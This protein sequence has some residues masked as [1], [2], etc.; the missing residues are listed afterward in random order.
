MLNQSNLVKKRARTANG[1]PQS[2][3]K[4]TATPSRKPFAPPD[5]HLD[6]NSLEPSST[7]A[8]QES[9][10]LECGFLRPHTPGLTAIA[11]TP[12]GDRM[13]VARTDYSI[14]YSRKFTQ[15]T[16]TDEILP[17]F[18]DPD[19]SVSCLQFTPC[20]NF[21]V[22]GR[23]N[24]TVTF[25]KIFKCGLALHA[26]LRPGGGAVWN[27]QFAPGCSTS[28]FRLAVACDDGAVRII[29]PDPEF[30]PETL[31]TDEA[32]Y[33]IKQTSKAQARA[34]SLTWVLSKHVASKHREASRSPASVEKLGAIVSGDSEGGLRL[35]CA[36]TGRVLRHGKIPASE[37]RPVLIWTVQSV[38]N[39]RKI[40]CGDDRGKLTIWDV[41]S[42]TMVSEMSPGGVKGAIW[43]STV[44][45][46]S[47]D[48]SEKTKWKTKGSSNRPRAGDNKTK[49]VVVFGC[50]NGRICG[51]EFLD[52]K[53]TK[54]STY[55]G[56]ALHTHDVRGIVGTSDGHFVSAS[57]DSKIVYA[58]LEWLGSTGGRVKFIHRLNN[59]VGRSCI[60]V[61]KDHNIVVCRGSRE[62]EIWH[63]PEAKDGFPKLLLRMKF[64]AGSDLRTCSLSQDCQFLALSDAD[65]FRLYRIWDGAGESPG[66][67]ASFGKVDIV[68]I[69]PSIEASLSGCVSV[70]FCRGSV[71]A[72]SRNRM[73]II[74]YDPRSERYSYSD[75]KD[76]HSKGLF[77]KFVAYG[78][79]TIAT[80]DS[81]NQVFV[82]KLSSEDV[83]WQAD[84]RI[85]N[86]VKNPVAFS[87]S[88]SGEK[89]AFATT[90]GSFFV[91]RTKFSTEDTQGNA[92]ITGRSGKIITC[93]TFGK[94]E[95]N[96]LVSGLDHSSIISLE[97]GSVDE[98]GSTPK[99]V[100]QKR[101]RSNDDA[102]HHQAPSTKTNS[103]ELPLV[104]RRLFG[105][106]IL[107]Q[108]RILL[109][110]Q[111]TELL[112][113]DL[114]DAIPSKQ[115]TSEQVT[116]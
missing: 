3:A 22:A 27:M 95:E 69:K 35:L 51:I 63:L 116:N 2:P 88:P 8:V 34:L 72:L 4:N 85:P 47:P 83:Q 70:L 107:S 73:G 71:V 59:L 89:V 25:W 14:L 91:A 87:L 79:S 103:C 45:K 96:M 23:L 99:A 32:H 115:F 17:R 53:G 61:V 93:L 75:M 114:P 113:S 42:M 105:S 10:L 92:T 44:L 104:N 41:S 48:S 49:E 16:P 26:E 12:D 19:Q 94:S 15:W 86:Y 7:P 102:E 106:G 20:S 54:M 9:L 31:P 108:G 52:Q 80:V 28:C 30:N 37:E 38:C 76:W 111:N 1:Y 78:Q 67:A 50:A 60:Q 33:I 6:H 84:L 77:L 110:V 58:P 62:I 40:V 98:S 90:D 11:V 24:G 64:D 5:D 55:R 74:I 18:G 43:T 100:S 46:R 97:H 101:K 65:S 57:I 66:A 29:S 68:D 81:K 13:A 56:A 36:Q 82:C 39:E 21:L 109:L 112:E